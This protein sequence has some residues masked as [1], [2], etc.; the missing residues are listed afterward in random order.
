MAE[1][2]RPERI[3]LGPPDM[4]DGR[5]LVPVTVGGH[6]LLLVRDGERIVAA[7]RACPHEGADLL[8]GRCVGGRL[9]CPRHLASFDLQDGSVSPGW[10]FRALRLFD[11]ESASDGLWLRMT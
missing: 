6:H 11:I 9:H 2:E 4:L 7:E 1:T 10:S 5:T 8:L 3:R